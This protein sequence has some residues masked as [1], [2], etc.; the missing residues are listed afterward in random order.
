MQPSPCSYLFNLSVCTGLLLCG[1]Y[2]AR[3][4]GHYDL[5][6]LMGFLPS[7]SSPSDRADGNLPNSPKLTMVTTAWKGTFTVTWQAGNGGFMWSEK[8]GGLPQ[9]SKLGSEGWARVSLGRGSSGVRKQCVQRPCGER[10]HCEHE[11]WKEH[12]GGP[13]DPGHKMRLKK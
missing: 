13:R 1:R 8:L 12:L 11:G 10:E 5:T 2:C 9:E 3:L 7:R 4:W 6:K